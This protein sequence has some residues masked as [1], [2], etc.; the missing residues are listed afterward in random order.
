M[1]KHKDKK[2]KGM[3]WVIETDN[4]FIYPDGWI[5]GGTDE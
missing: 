3:P 1:A 2:P 4:G 5:D